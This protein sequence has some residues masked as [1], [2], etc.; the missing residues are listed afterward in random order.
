M[1]DNQSFFRGWE[2]AKELVLDRGYTISDK[3][4]KLSEM[5]LNYLINNDTLDMIGEKPNK[6]K[7]YIKFINMIRIKVAY[8]QTII[9]DIKK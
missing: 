6:D 3:Y 8:L 2:T 7:I 9:D 4:N 5:D 1:T